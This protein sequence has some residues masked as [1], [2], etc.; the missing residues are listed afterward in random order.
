VFVFSE[1]FLCDSISGVSVTL[2][3]DTLSSV[4]SDA[5]LCFCDFANPAIPCFAISHPTSDGRS[6]AREFEIWSLCS[7]PISNSSLEQRIPET[8][9]RNRAVCLLQKGRIK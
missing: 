7:R 5:I 8:Q 4:P 6:P 9:E 3:S 1:S 2:T